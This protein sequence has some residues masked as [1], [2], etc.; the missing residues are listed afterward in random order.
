MSLAEL[1]A[2][3]IERMLLELGE[4]VTYRSGSLGDL[5]VRGIFE[6]LGSRTDETDDGR[7]VT[8]SGRM[9][10]SRASGTGVPAWDEADRL[11]YNGRT[12]EVVDAETDAADVLVLMIQTTAWVRRSAKRTK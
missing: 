3:E 7:R 12:W 6:S 11:D 10:F 2:A 8:L 5:A 4:A 9:C 1:H